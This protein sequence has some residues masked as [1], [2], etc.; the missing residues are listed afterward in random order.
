[1]GTCYTALTKNS[2][3]ITDLNIDGNLD[4]G[5]YNLTTTGDLTASGTITGS[6]IK[7][8]IN[9]RWG[10]TGFDQ[11]LLNP[12]TT[13]T[14]YTATS[15]TYKELA[16][17]VQTTAT[18]DFFEDN[19][20]Y[21]YIHNVFI[22]GKENRSTNPLIWTTKTNSDKTG[23]LIEID[24]GTHY[25]TLSGDSYGNFYAYPIAGSTTAY[26]DTIKLRATDTTSGSF[27]INNL[28]FNFYKTFVNPFTLSNYSDHISDII[29][30]SLFD[31]SDIIKVGTKYFNGTS[32]SPLTIDL[33][34]E[35]ITTMEII[36]GN[37]LIICRKV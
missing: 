37:P 30:V 22:R 28:T 8:I 27:W 34:E 19:A 20:N 14:E 18:N 25:I 6:N 2:I 36:S 16:E 15:G 12:I 26:N 13:E 9:V 4:L 32:K 33:S 31:G 3:N 7:D 29:G 24:G 10:L 5:S 11:Y 21:N 1:M 23:S 35:T 17:I